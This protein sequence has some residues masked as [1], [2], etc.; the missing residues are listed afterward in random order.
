MLQ[1]PRFLMQ[2]SLLIRCIAEFS[3]NIILKCVFFLRSNFVAT[4]NFH[5]WSLLSLRDHLST[6]RNSYFEDESRT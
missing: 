3:K 4:V 6:L 2:K 1:F 5:M